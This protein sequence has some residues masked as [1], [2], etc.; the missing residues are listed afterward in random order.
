MIFRVALHVAGHVGAERHDLELVLASVREGVLGQD[1]GESVALQLGVH[2]GVGKYDTFVVY[3][4]VFR[5][6]EASIY[7]DF[8]AAALRV[9]AHFKRGWV[10]L[11]GQLF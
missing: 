6:G 7:F 8:K 9:V 11:H 1:G 10:N 5:D 2:L 4:H 3:N